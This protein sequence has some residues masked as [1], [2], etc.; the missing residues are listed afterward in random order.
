MKTKILRKGDSGN[1]RRLFEFPSFPLNTPIS[2]IKRSRGLKPEDVLLICCRG[3]IFD[4]S[5][6]PEIYNN[7]AI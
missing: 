1:T 7:E 4:V 5:S 3:F 6:C 2:S